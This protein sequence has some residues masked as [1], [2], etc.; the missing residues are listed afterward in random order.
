ML[1][2]YLALPISLS[3]QLSLA[4]VALAIMAGLQ[5]VGP[6]AWSRQFFIAIVST[7]IVKYLIWRVTSTLPP[8]DQIVDF[9]AAVVLFTAEIY[10]IALL[11]MTMFV[12]IDPLERKNVPLDE[13]YRPSVDVFVPTFDE[14]V[15]LVA[16]TLAAAKAMD[17]DADRLTV[18]LLDDGGTTQK[19]TQND[20]AAREA[21]RE[22]RADL[23]E[24]CNRLDVRYLARE[25]NEM[26]KAGNLNYGLSQACG[27]LVVVLDA[28]HAPRRN[29]LRETVGHFSEDERLF[30]V[31]TPHAF[32]N[33]DPIERNLSA[34]EAMPA[35]HQMFYKSIQ[36]GLDSWNSAY[37]CGS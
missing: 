28:D 12:V 36:K 1:L 6:R 33:D 32:L 15:D 35:E 21:A 23:M 2:G 9:I 29:F 30:L 17:Y 3:A 22:R 27:E 26:A 5:L 20:D 16:H 31:Q 34:P 13:T 10:S 14:S 18:W 19:I 25:R 8:F 11:Y 24:L 4:L 7:I 37:F